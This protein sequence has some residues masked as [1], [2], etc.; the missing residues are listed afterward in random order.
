MVDSSAREV[1][2]DH[3][4]RT[5]SCR[6]GPTGRPAPSHVTS[7][8]SRGRFD[9]VTW[10]VSRSTEVAPALDDCSDDDDVDD[11]LTAPVLR[12]YNS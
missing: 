2:G 1:E 12:L 4:V 8:M 9:D 6:L 11:P 5:A 10:C 3:V 7:L